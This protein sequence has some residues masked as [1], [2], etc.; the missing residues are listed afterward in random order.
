MLAMCGAQKAKSLGFFYYVYVLLCLFPVIPVLYIT[1]ILTS[2]ML[3]TSQGMH[4]C[5]S[6]SEVCKIVRRVFS[7]S[8][9]HM[10]LL[11]D[12]FIGSKANAGV[13]AG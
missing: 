11:T 9:E 8:E 3:I 1:C 2:Q 5:N 4:L 12:M 7:Q 13:D 10:L 6:S